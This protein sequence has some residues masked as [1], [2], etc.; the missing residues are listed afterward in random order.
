MQNITQLTELTEQE[1]SNI[2]GGGWF[3]DMSAAV[4][5]IGAAL[6]AFPEAV[7]AGAGILIGDG[8]SLGVYAV[9]EW[10]EGMGDDSYSNK[11]VAP[12]YYSNYC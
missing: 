5:L 1:I 6:C 7:A 9:D 12:S 2:E 8:V 10:L 11:Y 4:G 3:V